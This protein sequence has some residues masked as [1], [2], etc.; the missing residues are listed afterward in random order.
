MPPRH[1]PVNTRT[2]PA[3]HGSATQLETTTPLP[4]LAPT[5]R[6]RAE[7]TDGRR[8]HWAEDVVDNEG[9]GKK[10]SKG[11]AVYP[12]P[13]PL[14]PPFSTPCICYVDTIVLCSRFA[15]ASLLHIPR[16]PRRRRILVRE[17]QL[18]VFRLRS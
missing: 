6:L 1:I 10:K 18:L 13:S 5:L 2:T 14:L 15:L 3:N 9:M 16:S 7:T 12:P 17:R 4:H 8:I 11:I